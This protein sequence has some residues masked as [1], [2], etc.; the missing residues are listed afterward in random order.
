MQWLLG[1]AWTSLKQA[2]VER[3]GAWLRLGLRRVFTLGLWPNYKYAATIPVRVAIS[4]V[5]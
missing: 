1:V 3:N 2:P 5:I 4:R